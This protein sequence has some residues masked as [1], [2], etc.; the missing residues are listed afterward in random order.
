MSEPDASVNDTAIPMTQPCVPVTA[1]ERIQ[2][3]LESGRLAQ[4]PEVAEFERHCANMAGTRFAAATNTGTSALYLALRSNNVGPGDEVITTPFSF[5]ATVNAVLRCGARV[6][7]AD[8]GDDFLLRADDLVRLINDATKAILPVHL[9]GQPCDMAAITAIA[10]SHA[11]SVIEDAAQAHGAQYRDRCVGS[12][13]TGAFSFYATKNLSTGE[14]GVVTTDDEAVIERVRVL[15]NQGMRERYE[16]LEVGD[17]LR[18][19]ELH[20]ALGIPQFSG[21]ADLT[22]AR[23]A[24]AHIY[25]SRLADIPEVHVPIVHTDRTHV[26]HQ[27]TVRLTSKA[28][29]ARS[30]VQVDLARQGI[31]SAVYY[32]QPLPFLPCYSRHPL[33]ERDD[34]VPNARALCEEVLS[35]PMYPQLS[36]SQA[37]RVADTLAHCFLP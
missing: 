10:D 35:V 34:P 5:V 24:V 37:E 23:R 30:A 1:K 21:L 2:C 9:F 29:V 20:A 19:S 27:F 36:R 18:M 6:R 7:F 16:Y 33:V 15:R 11:I 4:G 28:R 14:G 26:W 31:A 13:G 22:Q 17:N 25:L 12:F 8:V 32:P 3:V